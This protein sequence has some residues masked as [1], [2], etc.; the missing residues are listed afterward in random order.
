MRRTCGA[1]A[2]FA[3]VAPSLVSKVAR[4][5]KQPQGSAAHCWRGLTHINGY[6]SGWKLVPCAGIDCLLVEQLPER[7]GLPEQYYI[8]T[9]IGTHVAFSGDKAIA[10]FLPSDPGSG[11][12][13]TNLEATVA[14]L[15]AALDATNRAREEAL[16]LSRETIQ[17]CSRSIRALH[18]GERENA[19]RLAAEARDRVFAVRRA[20]EHHPEVYCSGYIHD[21]QKEYV[22]AETMLAILAQLPLPSHTDLGVEPAAY[23]NGIAEAA[24]ECRR[25]VLDR[26]I[27]GDIESATRTL[28][29]MDEI[30]DELV[31]VDYP[32]AVTG[33]LR[34][35]T[36]AL[37]AVLERTRGD[38]ALAVMTRRLE[39][40][41]GV[42]NSSVASSEDE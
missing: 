4:L 22:E 16:R 6:G 9:S 15:R 42:R 10:A 37:R 26:M 8:L 34:R 25:Y 38:M 29:A 33:G 3:D 17:F 36:D 13:T 27:S 28:R 32:D 35:T 30:Y 1:G 24:S 5:W 11:K 7:S 12:S 2:Q 14:A 23:L 20:T 19:A 31:A 18:R 39:A 40:S 41:I 21:S